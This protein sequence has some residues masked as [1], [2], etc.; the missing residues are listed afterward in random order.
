MPSFLCWLLA[1]A[2]AAPPLNI[3]VL[4][5]DDWRHDTLG[6]AG[7]PVVQTPHLDR[8]AGEGIRFTQ[9]CVT[10]SICGVSRA[11]CSPGSGCRA[12]AAGR[13]QP[14][15]TPWAE[16]YPGLLRDQRLPC[17]A[18]RQVAQRQDSRPRITTFGRA[19]HGKHWYET[20]TARKIHVTKRNENDALEFLRH[21]ARRTSRSA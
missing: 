20:R 15:E 6:V 9:N 21:P 3:L 17:R 16:T 1:T 8:L 4:Y 19:Y 13:S 7:N 5:A 11:C 10:T 2:N 12:T 14:F 18:R